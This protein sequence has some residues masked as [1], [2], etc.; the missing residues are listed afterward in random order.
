MI[1]AWAKEIILFYYE[2]KTE[3]IIRYPEIFYLELKKIN[4]GVFNEIQR[5][6]KKIYFMPYLIPQILALDME[7]ELFE[8]WNEKVPV[9]EYAKVFKH[10]F[11]VTK[12]M[13]IYESNAFSVNDFCAVLQWTDC[14]TAYK[15]KDNI[16][17]KVYR[18]I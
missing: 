18:S 15:R 12:G 10:H 11:C 17:I 2:T 16:G 6:D 4:G 9:E 5:I 14:H 1:P 7:T 3:K 13:R 8:V